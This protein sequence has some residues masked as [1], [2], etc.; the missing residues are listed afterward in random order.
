MQFTRVFWALISFLILQ[1]CSFAQDKVLLKNEHKAGDAWHVELDM[2]LNGMLKIKD[3]EKTVSLN[4]KATAK[5]RFEERVLMVQDGK[6]TSVG[7]FYNEA[8]ADITLQDK[9]MTKTLRPERK[10]QSAFLNT[11]TG[12][13]TTYSPNGALTDDELDLTGDH[14]DVLAIHGILPNKEVA[15]G[16]SW[17]L[18]LPAAQA[19]TGMEA[20]I[21][22]KLQVK[23]EKIERNH[24]VLAL[25]GEIQGIVKG[26]TLK[27]ELAV[28]LVY[29]LDAKHF[30]GCN[31]RHR[32]TKDQGPVNPASE[33]ETEITANWRHNQPLTEVTEA[34]A[35][36][37]SAQ[38]APGLLLMEFRDADNRFAFQYDRKWG[39]VN[40]SEKQTVL[41]LLDQ[42]E[43]IA[44]LNISPYATAKQG[45][46]LSLDDLE[47]LVG[48]SA[49]FKLEKVIE[50]A[51]VASSP[52]Q[53]IGKVSATGEATELPM[54]QIVYAIAGPRGDQALLS[55]TVEIEH[56][57]KLASRD[58]SLVKTFA[59]PTIQATGGK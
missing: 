58:L 32:E 1:N 10:F 38:P 17:D 4:L 51:E 56:A 7:R 35:A 41:R 28:G 52:G 8:K 16:E 43:L 59:L 30:T 55:F 11:E 47:K 44:Q 9:T 12:L 24:A 57:E 13:T 19:L 46:H 54:Q 42:G 15:V 37:I 36:T 49:G 18:P 27:S 53:W 34:K 50:K 25:T 31:W 20:V 40:K 14:L 48:E 3:G 22:S 39:V 26:A 21:A 6:P 45:Q 23:L 2:K 33:V 5:H 29:S